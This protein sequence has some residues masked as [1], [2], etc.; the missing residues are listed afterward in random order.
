MGHSGP[1][2]YPPDCLFVPPALRSDV[3]PPSSPATWVSRE[4]MMSSSSGSGGPPLNHNKPSCQAPADFLQPL[5]YPGSHISLDFITVL[6][7]SD[8]NRT[9]L[10]VVDCFSKMVHFVPL[11][12]LPSAKETTRL[13]LL[14]VFWLHG[15]IKDPRSRTPDQGPQIKNPRSRTPD[16]EP[17][18]TSVF[19]KEFCRQLGFHHQSVLRVPPAIQ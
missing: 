10:T 18:I 3:L 6:P 19:W 16:Q 1:N 2:A 5:L 8:G 11:H 17:Q 14:N 4:P 15:Q 12:K 13:V 9:I 7:P